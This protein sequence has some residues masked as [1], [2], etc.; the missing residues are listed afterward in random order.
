MKNE[1][2]LLLLCLTLMLSKGGTLR[3]KVLTI[4]WN[5]GGF[6]SFAEGYQYSRI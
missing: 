6:N 2:L 3:L 1:K 5:R 4:I